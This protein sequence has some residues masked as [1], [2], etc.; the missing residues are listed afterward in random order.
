[1]SVRVFVC[2]F[3]FDVPFKHLLSPTSQNRISKSLGKSNGKKWS[4]IQKLLLIKGVKL[5]HKKVCFGANLALLCKIL[6]EFLFL[7]PI[8][9]LLAPTSLSPLCKLFR[10]L[11]SLGEK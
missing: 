3:T 9:G 10:F 5:P 11:E 2:V 6:L 1:M 8:N 7:T 4:H